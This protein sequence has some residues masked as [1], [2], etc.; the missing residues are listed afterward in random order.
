[1]CLVTQ[2]C[3][4]LCEPMDCSPPGSSVHGNFP[5]KNTGVGCHVLLQG[6][7]PTHGSNLGLP[8]WRWILY[9]LS[10]QGSPKMFL[11]TWES[12]GDPQILQIDLSSCC[13]LPDSLHWIY[14][15]KRVISLWVAYKQKEVAEYYKCNLE[16]THWSLSFLG[17]FLSTAPPEG[18]GWGKGSHVV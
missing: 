2:S 12:N 16:F 14:L 17:P 9:C 5:G 10:H 1:M 6:I 13:N 15:D 4:P 11:T 3:L 7:F 8:H 18:T